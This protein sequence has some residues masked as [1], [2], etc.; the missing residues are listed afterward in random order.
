MLP[1]FIKGVSKFIV[2]NAPVLLTG[3]GVV[4]VV[5]TTIL[6]YEA[7]KKTIE[8]IVDLR[9]EA[10]DKDPDAEEIKIEKSEIVKACWKHWI[11]VATTVGVT[12]VSIIAAHKI[13]AGKIAALA[14]AYKISEDTRKYYKQAVL[15]KL[16]PNK[17]QDIKE[18]AQVESLN[19]HIQT[20][21]DMSVFNVISTGNGDTLIWDSFCGRLFRSSRPAIER[22]LATLS[23]RISGGSFAEASI[24]AIYDAIDLPHPDWFDKVVWDIDGSKENTY[25]FEPIWGSKKLPDG[26][27]IDAMGF[28]PGDNIPDFAN[29]FV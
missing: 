20:V 15:D 12:I 19:D 14:S 24:G 26:T 29:C 17:A 21:D 4:G 3:I 5:A 10:E 27:I 1:V 9:L 2:K 8:D 18:L 16:G 28:E 7:T 13:N 22:Q 25:H 6:T 11:P 23:N